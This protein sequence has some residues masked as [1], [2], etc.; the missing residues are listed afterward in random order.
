MGSES[1]SVLDT[2]LSRSMTANNNEAQRFT[3]AAAQAAA[4]TTRLRPLCLARQSACTAL[5]LAATSGGSVGRISANA[6]WIIP[7]AKPTATPVR[8]AIV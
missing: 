1:C 7:A 6:T 4:A 8:Q 3:A 2:P 5:Y